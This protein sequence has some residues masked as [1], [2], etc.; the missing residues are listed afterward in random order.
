MKEILA[1]QPEF[2]SARHRRRSLPR[3][4]LEAEW[5]LS[6]M[7]ASLVLMIFVGGPLAALGPRGRYVFDA[8]FSL[9][10]LSGVIAVP[11]RRLLPF[12][13]AAV[14]LFALVVRWTTHGPPSATIAAWDDV[15]SILC[16]IMFCVFVLFQV[17][18][19]GRITAYRIQGAI[20]AYLLLGL[21]WAAAYGAIDHVIPGAFQFPPAP[22]AAPL[23]HGLAYYS[24][25]TLTTLGYGDIVPLHPVARSLSMAEAL[26]G[27]LY[28][29]IL[30]ARLVSMELSS[31]RRD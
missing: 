17:F 23:E 30:I 8:F 18:R 7:L 3:L 12:A 29:A 11:R 25:V 24:F 2:R 16:L 26:V 22:V 6:A 31:R 1:A 21:V 14:T 4:R 9:V 15:L 28:P 10:L 20:V 27:Q 5:G 19:A 13:V